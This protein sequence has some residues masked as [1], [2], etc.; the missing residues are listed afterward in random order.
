MKRVFVLNGHPA[1]TS[2]SRSL[3]L[4]Y[5]DAASAAGHEVRVAHLHDLDFDSDFGSGGFKRT[6]PL[7]PAL[8]RVLQDLEWCEH[9]VIATP[10]WWG[11][12][13]AKLKGLLDRILL[14]GRA[15]DSRNRRHGMPLPL[16]SGRSGRVLLTSD[17]PG[18]FF[19]LVYG[20]A[21]LRQL[22]GQVFAV[23][24]IKPAR[25]THF[26]GASHPKTGEVERWIGAV[27]TLAAG[28]C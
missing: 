13:P 3:S 7:E 28:A 21:L 4:A 14:P 10:M 22:R 5:A 16:L 15:F 20:N 25:F 11:G 26:S 23:I 1:E 17:T 2:V 6:K 24:G 12:L 8:D 19:R 9:L 18:W 27:R